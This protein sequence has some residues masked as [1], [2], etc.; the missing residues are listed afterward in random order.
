MAGWGK[1]K[2]VQ[3]TRI[4]DEVESYGEEAEEEVGWQEWVRG[5]S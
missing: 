4:V 3:P 1:L 2:H 5:Q